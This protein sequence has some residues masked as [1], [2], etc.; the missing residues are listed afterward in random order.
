MNNLRTFETYK[1]GIITYEKALALQK[2][3]MLNIEESPHTGY[4]L[5][6]SHPHVYT[7]GRRGS[8]DDILEATDPFTG[9]EISIIQSDRGGLATYHGPSQLICYLIFNLKNW[10]GVK[11]YVKTLEKSISDSLSKIGI[12]S[13]IS[14]DEIG[15]WIKASQKQH[16]RKIAFI[17]IKVSK[18]ITSHGFSINVKSCEE[19]FQKIVP[20]GMPNLNVTSIEK[21]LKAI[22]KFSQLESIIG[23]S[24]SENF[25]IPLSSENSLTLSSR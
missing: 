10:G 11:K 19:Y 9:Q 17:G 18:G 21:E 1:L 8:F 13:Y 2:Q 5:F 16:D 22:P 23:N 24:I 14:P 4:L 7:I 3:L 20:C 25:Q 12:E 6:L 15:V